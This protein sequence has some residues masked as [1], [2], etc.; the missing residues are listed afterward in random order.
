MLLSLGYVIKSCG[1]DMTLGL[2]AAKTSR[3]YPFLAPLVG[4]LGVMVSGSAT[5][6]NVLFGSLQVRS[7]PRRASAEGLATGSPPLH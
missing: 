4:F 1:M 3:A 7:P 2:A 6:S 5:T